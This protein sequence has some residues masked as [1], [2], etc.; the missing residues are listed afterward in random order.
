[1]AQM[2]QMAQMRDLLLAKAAVPAR[3]THRQASDAT[4]SLSIWRI[5][6]IWGWNSGSPGEGSPRPTGEEVLA[7]K[8]CLIWDFRVRHRVAPVWRMKKF[9]KCP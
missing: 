3:G 6:D 5:C 7:G 2:A 8:A 9:V 4:R 1:M